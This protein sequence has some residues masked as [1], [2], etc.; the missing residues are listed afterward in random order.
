MAAGEASREDVF[1]G[2]ERGIYVPL[3]HYCG[4]VHP[5][6]D[7][8]YR[9]DARWDVLDRTWQGDKASKKLLLPIPE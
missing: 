1:M 7:A 6:E 5:N 2:I 4:I 8:F 9:N 3:F